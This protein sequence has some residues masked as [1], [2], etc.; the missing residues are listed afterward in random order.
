[1]KAMTVRVIEKKERESPQSI[2]KEDE[3]GQTRR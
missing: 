3:N 1:M 2:E